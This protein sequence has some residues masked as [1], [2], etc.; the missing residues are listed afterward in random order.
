[1]FPAIQPNSSL[2]HNIPIFLY[3]IPILLHHLSTRFSS[4]SNPFLPMPNTSP[5]PPFSQPTLFLSPSPCL[6]VHQ[7]ASLKWKEI[8]SPLPVQTDQ[9]DRLWASS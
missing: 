4:T 7:K 2:A 3:S 6:L 9:G 5:P 1:M 8:I